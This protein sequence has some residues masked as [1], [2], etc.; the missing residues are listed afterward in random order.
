MTSD[1]NCFFFYSKL[2]MYLN[3]VYTETILLH[4]KMFYVGFVP[5]FL[6][7]KTLTFFDW[8]YCRDLTMCQP[9]FIDFEFQKES[10]IFAL[11]SSNWTEMDMKCKKLILFTM[12]MNNAHQQKLKFSNM[13]VFSLEMFFGVCIVYIVANV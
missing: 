1:N 6:Y 9:T 2:G 11:Y 12:N 13:R 4:Q 3:F 8:K 7:W 10:V 5:L